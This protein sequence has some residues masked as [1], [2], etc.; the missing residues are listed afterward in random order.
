MPKPL[1]CCVCLNK[2]RAEDEP[3]DVCKTCMKALA[4]VW[5]TDGWAMM[6][7]AASLARRAERKRKGALRR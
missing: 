1:G 2:I 4:S 3:W 7:T 5:V 6:K